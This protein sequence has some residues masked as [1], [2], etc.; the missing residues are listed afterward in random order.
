MYMCTFCVLVKTGTLFSY[1]NI[2]IVTDVKQQ[3]KVF[4]IHTN[5][6]RDPV[7]YG[8][9]AWKDHR[10]LETFSKNYFIKKFYVSFK[11]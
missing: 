5:T 4:V 11:L 1:T 6:A 7:V 9:C 2:R 3:M 8:T 10:K